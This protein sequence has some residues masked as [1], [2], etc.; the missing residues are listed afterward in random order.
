[1]GSVDKRE[2]IRT[3][4]KTFPAWTIW[5]IAI[6][7]I[8]I[9]IGASVK[10]GG[11]AIGMGLFVAVVG[12]I[13]F[14]SNS[15]G[16]PT[17]QQI[18]KWVGTELK[19]FPAIALKKLGLEESQVVG[20]YIYLWSPP[21]KD[22]QLALRGVK[23]KEFR[24]RCGKDRRTRFSRYK[25]MILIPTEDHLGVFTT[26]YNFIK[27]TIYNQMTGEYFYKDIVSIRT[28]KERDLSLTFTDGR[29]FDISIPS[30]K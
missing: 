9:I 19:S 1:M 8:L 21:W 25:I 30:K 4:F 16:K 14:V 5:L 13:G 12:I 7:A 6:G 10:N 23:F 15:T 24:F 27:N 11:P 22:I 20:N 17:D 29:S 28:E 3:Y 26:T 2:K 18:D